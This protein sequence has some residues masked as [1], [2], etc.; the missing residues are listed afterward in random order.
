[1]TARRGSTG[2]V[3][4]PD[5]GVSDLEHIALRDP[6]GIDPHALLR[7]TGRFDEAH[8]LCQRVLQDASEVARAIVQYQLTRVAARDA[9]VHRV[10]EAMAGG[11]RPPGPPRR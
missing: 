11:K 1:V 7:R 4:E 3:G 6:L 10:D 2:L 9:A 8:A 5:L